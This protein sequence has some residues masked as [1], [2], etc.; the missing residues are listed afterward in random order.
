MYNSD[1]SDHYSFYDP[2]AN[3][4]CCDS[5]SC[6]ECQEKDQTLD[7]AASFLE[8]IVKQLYSK[9]TLDRNLLEFQLDELCH[10]L[11]VKT[12]PGDLTITREVQQQSKEI[13]FW[14]NNWKIDNNTYLKQLQR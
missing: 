14:L 5:Y 1:P 9:D 7:N 12:V 2:C 13:P 6:K 3:D 11:G 8:A 4:T 10:Y